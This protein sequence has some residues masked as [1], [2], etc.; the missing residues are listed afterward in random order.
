[1]EFNENSEMLAIMWKYESKTEIRIMDT[2][3][4]KVPDKRMIDDFKKEKFLASY[5]FEDSQIIEGHAVDFLDQITF[6]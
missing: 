2:D 3:Y 1:M 4:N 5:S 6:D